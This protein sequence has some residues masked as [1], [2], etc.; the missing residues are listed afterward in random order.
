MGLVTAVDF[1]STL[2]LL[3]ASQEI[4]GGVAAGPAE[5]VWVL[6][7]YAASGMFVIPFLARLGRR[8]HYRN[9]MAA[10]LV[11][12]LLGA[13]LAANSDSAAQ[14]MFAR[15]VQGAGG[16]GLF[17]LSRVYLQLALPK[18]RRAPHLRGYLLGLFGATAPMSWLTTLLVHETNWRSVFVLQALLALGVLFLVLTVLRSEHHASES[19]GQ[20]DWPMI[21]C[22]GGG[23]L[24][25][26][27]SLQDMEILHPDAWQ[28]CLLLLACMAL[29][30]A[31]QR[32]AQHQDP[33]LN[34]RLLNGR[35]YLAG[36]L[37]YGFYYLINGATAYVYPRIFEEGADFPL[38]TTGALLSLASLTTALLLPLYFRL[39]PRFGDR[40]KIIA[41][42]FAVAATALLWMALSTTSA[43]PSA[44]YVGPML[45]KGVFPLIGVVQIAGLTYL[46]V[47]HED[48][49][50]AYALKNIVRQL[51]NL[52]AAALASV[53]WLRLEAGFRT[54]LVSHIGLAGNTL[55][56]ETDLGLLSQAVDQ[57]VAVLVGN[58]LLIA[59]AL[60][61]LLGI[62]LVLMQ[63]SLK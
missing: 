24:L 35:R 34:M 14:L 33:L 11:V 5:F 4:R 1:T 52:L 56:S 47:Q 17:T 54:E 29:A 63:K 27:H 48:F 16:G 3:M 49:A 41:L 46:D 50:H 6:T 44:Q 15:V 10:G 21:L 32:L 8:W 25:L 13:L 36:L 9:L 28:M 45:L 39:S 43:T 26:L 57:Q 59:I 7:L 19:F 60:L 38:E 20:L 53:Y 30:F 2:S 12:F 51:A 23:S 42:S 31:W 18:E 58:S 55:Q 62:P 37:L 22:F 40:R 61:C